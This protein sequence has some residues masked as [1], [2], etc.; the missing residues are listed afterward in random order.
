[1]V[2][3]DILSPVKHMHKIFGDIFMILRHI[4]M[5]V[6]FLD[7]DMMRKIICAI[8]TPKLEHA[9]VIWSPHKKNHMLKLESLQRIATKLVPD[10][11]DLTYVQGKI[12]RSATDNTER[13]KRKRR[14]NY[15][16]YL[17]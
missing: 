12:K 4:R 17:K 13:K 2:I 3:Q 10:L 5:A 6:Y 9:E 7:K 14:L 1:M 11:A 16:S 8:I 15:N